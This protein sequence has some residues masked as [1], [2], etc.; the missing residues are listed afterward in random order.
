MCFQ[1]Q[2]AVK[3]NLLDTFKEKRGTYLVKSDK[4]RLWR[5]PS[6]EVAARQ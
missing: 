6:S 5:G 2:I 4:E 1:P 3:H